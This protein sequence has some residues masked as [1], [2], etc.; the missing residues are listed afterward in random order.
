MGN[1]HTPSSSTS[2]STSTN[3]NAEG[4]GAGAGGIPSAGLHPGVECDRSGMCP[5]I[6][7]RY[8]LKGHNYDLCQ[9]EYD[10]LN[11]EEKANYIA[12]PPPVLPKSNNNNH[13]FQFANAAAAAAASHAAA[14]AAA[15]FG[16]GGGGHHGNGGECRGAP[17]RHH[18]G[19][20]F[21]GGGGFGGGGFGHGGHGGGPGHGHG[22]RHWG[23]RGEH[24]N[25]PDNGPKLSA[26]FV[27]DVTIFDGTQM[28]PSTPF[29]KIWRL[30]NNGEVAWPPGTK[31]MFAGGD[32]MGHEMEVPLSRGSPVQPGE[33]VDV[34]V[35]MTA[36]PELGRYLGYWR[37]TGPMGRRKFGHRVWCHIQVVDPNAADPLLSVDE[38]GKHVDD[39]AVEGLAE[40]IEREVQLK[41]MKA[42]ET[43]EGEEAAAMAVAVV[44]KAEGVPLV[45]SQKKEE[46][47]EA[48]AVLPM[49]EAVITSVVPPSATFAAST[50]DFTPPTTTTSTVPIL[51]T[52]TAVGNGGGDGGDGGDCSD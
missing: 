2:T 14:A 15:A 21:G 42:V 25:G 51:P 39:A 33:E 50:S 5:I 26:R 38:E 13:P 30:K 9:S 4:G 3:N 44:A 8:N 36:P 22:G 23:P 1:H 34:A 40:A 28:A 18:R 7:M 52:T 29:T 45:S 49:G 37:L 11:A 32:A 35:S 48:A 31:M 27:R 10:K 43:G 17:W 46:E 47:E 19:G 20:M 12:I 24:V 16:G 41:M 6:G